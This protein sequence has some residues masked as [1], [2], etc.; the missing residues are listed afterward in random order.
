MKRL[1]P[2]QTV[3]GKPEDVQL[4]FVLV[5]RDNTESM[6]PSTAA[7]PASLHYVSRCLTHVTSVK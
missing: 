7:V 3:S 2:F 5:D 4:H 6:L 1:G